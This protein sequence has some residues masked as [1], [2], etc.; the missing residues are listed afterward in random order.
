VAVTLAGAPSAA[1]SLPD[2]ARRAL[3]AATPRLTSAAGT[4]AFSAR[5]VPSAQ[6]SSGTGKAADAASV[7]LAVRAALSAAAASAHLQAVNAFTSVQMCQH[8]GMGDTMQ[9]AS[10]RA[11]PR[12]PQLRPQSCE[13]Q[14][15]AQ[16]CVLSQ[17][18]GVQQLHVLP[19]P[20]AAMEQQQGCLAVQR[21][22]GV[23][24]SV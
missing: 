2:P 9:R 4:A 21:C 3:S 22:V 20:S 23:D 15:Q 19:G 17:A 12:C 18:D 16:E 14:A 5:S 24:P 11:P 13:R 8:K 1:R 7:R 10:W 6:R